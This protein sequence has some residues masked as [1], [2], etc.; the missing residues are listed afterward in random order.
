MSTHE[1]R[2]ETPGGGLVL[3]ELN[4]PGF[5]A[6]ASPTSCGTT[7]RPNYHRE[8]GDIVRPD[9]IVAPSFSQPRDHYQI[10]VA[11]KTTGELIATWMRDEMQ[12]SGRRRR[13]VALQPQTNQE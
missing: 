12:T 4:R 2:V 10:G 9:L 3:S 11:L 5:C 1:E 7:R 6:T 13:A 8:S